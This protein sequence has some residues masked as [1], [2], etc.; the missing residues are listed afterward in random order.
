MAQLNLFAPGQE[1]ASTTGNGR[2]NLALTTGTNLAQSPGIFWLAFMADHDPAAARA[3]FRRRYRCAP[4]ELR[5]GAG[6]L[7]LA[8]PVP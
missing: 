1:V 8:G 2:A 6:G 3:T 5:S 4:A 7:L